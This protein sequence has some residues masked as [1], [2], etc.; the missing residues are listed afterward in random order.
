VASFYDIRVAR[1]VFVL[2]SSIYLFGLSL[3]SKSTSVPLFE[4]VLSVQVIIKLICH[5]HQQQFSHF[6]LMIN[7]DLIWLASVVGVRVNVVAFGRILHSSVVFTDTRLICA[8]LQVRIRLLTLF[9]DI[10]VARV[11]FR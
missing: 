8:A 3:I 1:V 7:S 9:Y 2:V 4:L 10:R 11:S 6:L 5:L